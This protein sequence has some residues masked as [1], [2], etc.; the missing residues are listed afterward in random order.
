MANKRFE[1]TDEIIKTADEGMNKLIDKNIK[2][3]FNEISSFEFPLDEPFGLQV[4]YNDTIYCLVIKFSS[5]NKNLICTGP[6]AH[7][8]DTIR[9]GELLKPPFFD[10]WS[11]YKYFKESFIAYADPMFFY[12]DKIK[13][14]WL[15]GTK[16][17]WYLQDLSEIIEELCKNQEIKHSNILFYGSSGGGYT[18]VVLGTLIKNSQ[19]LINNSQL[20]I[21]NYWESMVNPVFDVL[22][23]SFEGMDKD[24]IVEKIKYRLDTIELFKKEN[25]APF[26][27][28]YV[29]AESEWD[30]KLH[31]TPFLKQIY[32]LKQFNGLDVVYYREIKKVPHEPMNS[33]KTIKVIKEYCKNYLYNSTDDVKSTENQNI[34]IEGKYISKLQKQNK[35]L[36]KKNKKLK[37]ENKE[38]LNSS[39]WKITSP[40]RKIK[41]IFK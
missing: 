26:I 3:N 41:K 5:K 17:H 7:E 20:F 40:L 35:R 36:K 32:K 19:V 10:R 2:L 39:S 1:L 14:A 15:I 16:E 30:I 27:T 25:Y 11:W 37:K 8:R 9:N 29:N 21:M 24:E 18:S 23:D 38:L 34:Y 6:G 28:Y 4:T 13:I 31:G 12:G 22:Y 33:D